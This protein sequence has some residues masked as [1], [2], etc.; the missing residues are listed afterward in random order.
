MALAHL[1]AERPGWDA[2]LNR[3]AL[4][5]DN[6]SERAEL[7]DQLRDLREQTLRVEALNRGER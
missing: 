7:Y 3:I 4:R 1:A 5:I 6:G 2:L